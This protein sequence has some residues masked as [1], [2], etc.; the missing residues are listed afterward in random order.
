MSQEEVKPIL[1]RPPAELRDR[2]EAEARLQKRSLNNLLIVI[3]TKFFHG[4][5]SEAHIK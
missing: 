3:L 2:L 4:Q 5:D 1:L